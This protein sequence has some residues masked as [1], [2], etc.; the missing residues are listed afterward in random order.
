MER[1]KI[2]HLIGGGEIGGAERLVLTLMKLLDKNRYDVQL[3][4]LCEG[5]FAKLVSEQGF[6]ATTLPMKHKLDITMMPPVRKYLLE[7]RINLVHTH[8]VRA[9]LI[10][11]PAAKKEGL[12]VVTTVHSVLQYDYDNI[13]KAKFARFITRLGNKYTDRFIAI[14]NSIAEELI[15]MNIPSNKINIIHSGLDISKF[16]AGRLPGE[17]KAVLGINNNRKII[18]MIA[19]LHPEG[20]RVLFAGRPDG[21]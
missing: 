19:R 21:C 13:L 2:V 5:P 12:P 16:A 14:S 6:K 3:I 17:V 9:N 8:G 7:N 10:G 1:N 20:P 4:C 18:S 11:R 15:E